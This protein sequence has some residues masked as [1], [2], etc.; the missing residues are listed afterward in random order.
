MFVAYYVNRQ[1]IF[2]LSTNINRYQQKIFKTR[3]KE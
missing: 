2:D 1:K 3:G